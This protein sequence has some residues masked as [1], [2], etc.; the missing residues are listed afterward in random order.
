M[1]DP[2]HVWQLQEAKAKLSEV[3]RL[4]DNEPQWIS[5]R[6]EEKAVMLSVK[7]YNRLTTGNHY[8]IGEFFRNS[9]LFGSG[10]D[11]TRDKSPGREVDL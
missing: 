11:L 7:E 2:M 6:G 9:P 1:E 10:I 8:S 5:S 3:V 4:C